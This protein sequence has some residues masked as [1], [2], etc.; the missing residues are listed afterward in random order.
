MTTLYLYPS[1]TNKCTEVTLRKIFNV[2]I[3][4]TSQSLKIC[5]IC[6]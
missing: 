6:E 4:T 1:S 3:K 5:F 2:E